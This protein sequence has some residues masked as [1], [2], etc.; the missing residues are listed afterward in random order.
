MRNSRIK[1][2]ADDNIRQPFYNK[3]KLKF[4]IKI[5]GKVKTFIVLAHHF[6]TIID[7]NV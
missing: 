2:L 5:G 1:D 6:L 7:I 4:K 3:E